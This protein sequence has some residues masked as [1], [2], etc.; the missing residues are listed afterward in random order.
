MDA[1][2][3]WF[4]RLGGPYAVAETA[5]AGLVLLIALV[6]PQTGAAAAQRIEQLFAGLA[7]YPVRQI[8]AVGALAVLARAVMLPWLGAP[9]PSIHDEQS[10]L[11]QAQTFLAG[12]LANPT[13]PFWEHFET[14]YVNHVPAYA[15]MYFPGRGAPLALGLLVADNAWVGV[16]ISFVLM[17]MAAVWMLQGWVSLP[18]A[19]LGGVIVVARFG[20]FSYWVNAYLG[21]AF[22]A[23]G[24]MLVVGALP[25]LLAA[26][27]WRHGVAMGLGTAILMNTRP[28]EGAL[29][30]VPVGAALLGALWRS[31]W[32]RHGTALVRSAVPV[33]L[34]VAAGGA[35]LLAYNVATTG[36]ALKTP[37]DLN[38]K[39]Y[40]TAPAFLISPPIRSEQ[41]GPEY[42][43]RFYASEGEPHMRRHSLS[44]NAFSAAGKFFHTGSF[45]TGATF[46]LAFLAGLW[47]S[48]KE[49]FLLGGLAFFVA[50]YLLET[51]NYP[52]YV[53]PAFPL[54]L[55]LLMRGLGWLRGFSLRGR[56]VGL[57]LSRAAPASAIL[58]LLVPISLLAFDIRSLQ[59]PANTQVCCSISDKN[60]RTKL[61]RELAVTPGRDLVLVKDGP[62][63]PL[64]FELVYN[65]PD[66]DNA[67]VVWARRLSPE[68]DRRLLAHFADR[69]VWEFEWLPAGDP[70]YRFER[71]QEPAPAQPGAAGTPT[72]QIR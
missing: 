52:Q 38:R 41:R 6:R 16:W 19:L 9:V 5:L 39:T 56:P 47:T 17:A 58:L 15:S 13:H 8:L 10:L 3:W 37:Y 44:G 21:G 71:I 50:G 68:Q 57:F 65:E 24:A 30:C 64:Y 2:S 23:F 54:L 18:L 35:L 66:I 43:R 48:R 61:L 33:A 27:R 26:P 60:L 32:A 34:F 7:H 22:A 25:R 49:T 51:W 40:A 55:I 63:N 59:N 62:M 14:F 28:Y 53:A 31:G 36:H 42:F 11:V 1:V 45:Y 72:S 29:L 20:V 70:G 67:P 46:T 4:G 69:I 12:R